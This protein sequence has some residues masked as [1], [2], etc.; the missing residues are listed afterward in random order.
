MGCAHALESL[1]DVCQPKPSAASV[2]SQQD[3]WAV[4]TSVEVEAKANAAVVVPTMALSHKA[5][6]VAAADAGS[7]GE[8]ATVQGLEPV[9]QLTDIPTPWYLQLTL[10]CN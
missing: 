10:D 3:P 7:V 2:D 4:P 6:A 8:V 5:V 9:E 1:S